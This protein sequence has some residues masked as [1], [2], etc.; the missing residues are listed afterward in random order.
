MARQTQE[1]TGDTQ[2]DNLEC[3][4]VLVAHLYQL[5]WA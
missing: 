3:T 4:G 1:K 2:E 5:V